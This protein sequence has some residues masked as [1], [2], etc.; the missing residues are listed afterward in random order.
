MPVIVATWKVESG[1]IVVG[2][3]LGQIVCETPISKTTRAKGTRGVTQEVEYL[4]CKNEA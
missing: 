2:G 3:H 4:F 1:R